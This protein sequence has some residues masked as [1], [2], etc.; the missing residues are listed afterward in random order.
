[1]DDA[2]AVQRIDVEL[3]LLHIDSRPRRH[4]LSLSGHGRARPSEGIRRRGATGGSPSEGLTE[5]LAGF[6]LQFRC[7][8]DCIWHEGTLDQRFGQ[9]LRAAACE[10]DRLKLAPRPGHVRF[11]NFD[12]RVDRDGFR[13]AARAD[14][15][16]NELVLQMRVAVARKAPNP[17]ASQQPLELPDGDVASDVRLRRTA[18]GS[19]DGVGFFVHPG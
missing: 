14:K 7:P 2:Q 13:N 3:I 8:T 17:S 4:T 11:D 6:V 19:L 1:M 12:E 10:N 9:G 5:D 15:C 16:G 18:E